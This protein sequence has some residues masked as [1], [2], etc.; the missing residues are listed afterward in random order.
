MSARRDAVSL[1]LSTEP[2]S[3]LAGVGPRVAAKL[4][5]RGLTWGEIEK[6]VREEA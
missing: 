3:R 1:D 2:L 6:L 4:E 5:A